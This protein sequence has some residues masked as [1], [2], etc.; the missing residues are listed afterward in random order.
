V[1]VGTVAV[2]WE[3]VSPVLLR[4]S[5]LVR[6]TI[7]AIAASVIAFPLGFFF[8]IGL[9]TAREYD[10]GYVAWAWAINSGTTV[11]GSVLAIAFAM[12]AGFTAVLLAAL[13][14]Y[15]LGTLAFLWVLRHDSPV[16]A[17]SP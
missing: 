4:G 2:G 9:A 10:R 3:V 11:L 7:S 16:P 6:G 17:G 14:I 5:F 12:W 15:V 8:P 1:A 13:G